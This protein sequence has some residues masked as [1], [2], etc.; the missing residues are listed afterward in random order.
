MVIKALPENW[1]VL[2]AGHPRDLERNPEFASL[3]DLPNVRF[4]GAKFRDLAPILAQASLVISVDTACLHLAV[5]VG[6]PTLC[7]ASAAY[8]GEIM[9]YAPE[10]A[11]ARFEVVRAECPQQGC[12]GACVYPAR[13]GMYPCIGDLDTEKVVRMVAEAAHHA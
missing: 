7:L 9:P 5:A 1:T 4:E 6:A 2:M 11:P 3:L 10:L 13:D 12:L 8:V